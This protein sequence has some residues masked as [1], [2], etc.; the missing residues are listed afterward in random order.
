LDRVR[1]VATPLQAAHVGH[2]KSLP[3]CLQGD[4]DERG[5]TL[6]QLD[7]DDPLPKLD[8]R[9]HSLEAETDADARLNSYLDA[10][11]V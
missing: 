2:I 6:D 1:A 3:W 7:L 9:F 5:D 4:P 8:E 10:K 11:P